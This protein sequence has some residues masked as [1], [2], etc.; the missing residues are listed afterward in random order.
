MFL[1]T[2]LPQTFLL[3]FTSGPFAPISAIFLVLSESSSIT[4]VIARWFL[5]RDALVDTFDATLVLE[6]ALD[7]LVRRGREGGTSGSTSGSGEKEGE[8]D[9]IGK[10]G[11]IR[12][13]QRRGEGGELDVHHHH[14]R[15]AL[16]RSLVYLP[17]NLVPVVGTLLY[18]GVQG[19]RM[20][21]IVHERYFQLKGWDGKR[22]GEW[23]SRLWGG[24]WR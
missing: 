23:V 1:F 9:L 12:K 6:G 13:P 19:G 17:L 14:T 11:R 24:Y 8:E 18:L 20:G 4:N 16:M 2:Y 21:R 22:R 3:S 15:Q 10:L 5:L 7:A